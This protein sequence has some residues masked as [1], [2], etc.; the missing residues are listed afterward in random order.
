[1]VSGRELAAPALPAIDFP[2]GFCFLVATPIGNLADIGLRALAV[3]AAA[4]V[5]YAEDTRHTRRL[6]SHYGLRATLDSYHDHNKER[7]VPRIVERLRRQE[8]VAVVSDAGMP[9]IA[10]PGYRLVRALCA[11]GLDWSVVPGPSSVLAGLLLSG[12]PSDRFLFAGYP[13]RRQGPRARFLEEV[14]AAPVTVVVLES[15]H[16]IKQT[17]T[18]LCEMAPARELALVREISK[19]HEETLR[20]TPAAV[21][22]QL[23]RDRLRG[24]FVLVLAGDT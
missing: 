2:P 11:E 4:D 12:L 22:A 20:G 13:P 21:M 17:V 1:M 8:R 23:S 6:L 3:L 15:C 9:G 14:L 18:Q 5:I 24:E 10:D 16:R 7:V 19:M